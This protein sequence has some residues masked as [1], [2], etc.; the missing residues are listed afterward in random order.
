MD[1][2][3]GATPNFDRDFSVGTWIQV[4]ED[5]AGLTGGL[6]SKFDPERRQGFNLSA[7]SSAGGYNGPGD[8]IRISFGIDAGTTPRWLEFGT[9]APWSNFSTSL[10]VFDGQLYAASNDGPAKSDWA[11]VSRHVGGTEW[12]DLGQVSQ[13]G[14]HGIGPLV[15]HR[16]SLYAASYTY[17]WTRVHHEDV[18]PCRVYRFDR[19][20]HW[21]DCGQPGNSKRLFAIGSYHGDLYVVGDDFSVQVYRGGQT[22]E[23]VRQLSTF[24]H[25]LMVHDGR[26]ALATWEH[27]PTVLLFDGA[28]WEDLGN[29]LGDAIRCSQIHSLTVFR[30]DLHAGHWPLGR[31]SRWN[32]NRRRWEQTG[33][34]GDSTEIN[35]LSVFNGKLY[36]GALPRAEV[37]RYECDGDWTSLRRFRDAPRWRPVLVR[38]MERPPH[39]DRRLREW[40]RATSLTQHE[41]LLFASITS[42]TGAAV[43]SPIDARGSVYGLQAGLVATTPRSL[44]PGWHHVAGV[45]RGGRVTIFVDGRQAAT[46][47][48]DVTGSVATEAALRI[49]QDEAGVYPGE[50]HGFVAADRAYDATDVARM[51]IG[52]R[53]GAAGPEATPPR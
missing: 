21:E 34:L 45:R 40:G 29:P 8:E 51:M 7:I 53:P 17:D 23:T 25:P 2:A 10:T 18:K 50:R 39:G 49:G 28:R 36:A 24:A 42:C 31:V 33:R 16:G 4:P 30:G 48:G 22:W 35:A 1:H 27:P 26:F 32:S 43:D 38:E 12:E 46:N 3:S 47:S 9:P 19:P 13:E 44:D 52:T 41:G 6:A 11:H 14:A 15:V 20:G 37:F 5:R